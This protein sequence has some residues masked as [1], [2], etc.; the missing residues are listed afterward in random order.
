MQNYTFEMEVKETE[1]IGR[2]GM[3]IMEVMVSIGV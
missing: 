2:A 3:D 1:L